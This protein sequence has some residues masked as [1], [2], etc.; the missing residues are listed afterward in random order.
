MNKLKQWL[1]RLS[2]RTGILLVIACVVCYIVS[3]AQMLLPI[4]VTAKGVFWIIFFGLAKTFQ[5]SALAVLGAEGVKRV[6]SWWIN[7][8]S[9]K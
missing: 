6:K 5:Y 3:F 7:R 8:K 1:S 4:S 9:K 2:F